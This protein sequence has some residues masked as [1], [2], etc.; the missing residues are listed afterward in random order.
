M[1]VLK[2][3]IELPDILEALRRDPAFMRNVT[4][5]EHM[6][7]RPARYGLFPANMQPELRQAL[8][9]RGIRQL[10]SHQSQAIEHTLA[11]KNV[12]V[13]TP[14]ASGKTLCYNI[15]VLNRILTQP[16]SR[17]LYLFPTKALSQDQMHEVHEIVTDMGRDIKVFTFDGDTPQSARKAIRTAGHIVVTNPDMLHQGIL[18][19]HTLWIKLF[20][21]LNYIVIDEIHHYRGVFGS[22]LANVLRRLRRVCDFYGSKPQ[23]ICCSATVANPKELAEKLIEAPVELV[24]DNGAPRGEKHF[25]FYNPPVVNMELGIRASS[26][27]ESQKIA[28]RFLNAGVQTIVFAR[29]RN[30]V[31]LLS[32]YLQEAVRRNAKLQG[33]VKGYRGGYLPGERREIEKGLRTGELLGVVSTNALELGIDIG[34]L[35]AC[36][37]SG[38]PG[39][40]ASAWQQA[41][42]AG[43]KTETSV[44]VLV[45]SSSPLDQYIINHPDFFFGRAP[46]SAMI[47]PN[48]LLIMMSHIKC[49]AFEL[50]FVENE[51]F[52]YGDF[53]VDA[54]QE[55]LEYLEEK[56]VLHFADGKWHWMAETYPAEAVSLRSAST[57]NVVIIDRTGEERVIGE[58]DLVSAPLYVHQDAIYMHG[59]ETYHVDRLDWTRKK[60]Y[61]HR[62]ESDYYTDAQI[63]SSLKVLDVFQHEDV[64]GGGKAHGEVSV[65]TVPTMYKKIRFRT[66]ENIGWGPIE[67]PEME[68]QTSAYWWELDAD[69]REVL[70][71]SQDEL[72]DAL[73]AAAN[74]LGHVAPI[75]IMA[76]PGDIITLPMVRSPFTD[77]PTVYIYERY[78]GGVGFSQ[79]L[80][81]CH[82]DLLKAAADVIRHC[83]CETG[84]PSCVGPVLEVGEHGKEA[85]LRLLE[86]RQGDRNAAD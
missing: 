58:I 82:D 64:P 80:F 19:H 4:H 77:L 79:K 67:L 55:I 65:T 1:S 60:A 3:N 54:T 46:E 74:V 42:R 21:N 40:I 53:V 78:P 70:Q 13:V 14:T 8:E 73:K 27:K 45:A 20:E 56:G 83:R 30:R 32:K 62:V 57:E 18:P 38:Y 81:D 5:W 84:C 75:F 29:S 72:G 68:L 10:Y 25:I 33:R 61:V 37:M 71:L 85:A 34:Q 52:G 9:K 26:V 35:Q 31:E 24:D 59:T 43:R 47:D 6:A 22:H 63:K 23:F 28:Q 11:G 76:D 86:F 7:A 17:A 49:A 41:G 51:K 15:P 39:T 50:P 69:I 36:V 2:P 12:V 48:N 44:A 66:H 16:E